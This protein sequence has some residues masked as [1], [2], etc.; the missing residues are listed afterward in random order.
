M[1]LAG[2]LL[3]LL[4]GL[5]GAIGALTVWTVWRLR[6]PPR[7]TTLGATL[8]GRPGDPGEMPSARA[9]RS[10]TIEWDGW[11]LPV[12]EIE[13]DAP[14]GPVMILTPGWGDS[15]IGALTRLDALAPVCSRVIAWDPPGLGESSKGRWLMGVREHGA[16]LK[17]IERATAGGERVALYG[18]SAGA[19]TS[20]AAAKEAK[21][22]ARERI[23]AVIAEAPYR[24]AWTPAFNVLRSVAMPYRVNGPLAFAWMGWRLGVGSRWRG[25]DRAERARGVSCPLLVLHGDGDDVCPVED[26][27]EIARAAGGRIEA[28]AGAGHNDLWTDERWAARC[29]DAVRG[30]VRTLPGLSHAFD[31]GDAEHVEAVLED[32]TGEGAEPQT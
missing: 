11:T 22:A 23:A 16:L 5:V 14:R 29:A 19:G 15:R 3:L 30:F 13:G 32:A 1:D 24:L 25:F 21:G 8:R 28:I 7:R 27:R 9:F 2:L 6:N 18:W 10:W 17:L 31:G 4:V 12:W 20:I 26:G